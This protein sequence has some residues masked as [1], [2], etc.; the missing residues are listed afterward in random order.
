MPEENG[1]PSFD[2]SPDAVGL[3]IDAT[4]VVLTFSQ[5][6]TEAES[7]TYGVVRL[8]R[9]MLKLTAFFIRENIVQHEQEAGVT[10]PIPPEILTLN[11]VDLEK[12]AWFWEQEQE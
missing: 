6:E 4:G 9:E 10:W 2:I 5:S 12:W 1:S 3:S 7:G 11:E 8:S